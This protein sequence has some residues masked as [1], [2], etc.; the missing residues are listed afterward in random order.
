MTN[1]VTMQICLISLFDPTPVDKAA[2]GRFIGIAEAAVKR[3]HSVQHFTSTFRHTSKKHRFPESKTLSF[4]EN[5]QVHFVHSAGYQKNM[6][7][8]RFWA[9]ADFAGK[10]IPKL[11]ASPRPDVIFV[12]MPP[13]SVADRVTNWAA[14]RGIPVILDVIDP[15]PD[16]FIKD[17]PMQLKGAARWAILPFARKLKRALRNC[18]GLS[19]I[20]REYIKWALSYADNKDLRTAYFYP[21]VDFAGI[22]EELDQLRR[23]NVPTGDKLRLIYAGSLASSYD[24]GCILEAARRLH[25]QYP[26]RTEFVI[27]GTGPQEAEIE[28]FRDLP[29]LAYL[30][31]LQR[32]E[33]I[34]QYYLSDLGF[35]QH[36]NSL[37]QTVTYKLFSYLSA[38][39]PV[40]NSLQSEMVEIIEEHEVG[41]NNKEG[42]VAQLVRNIEVFLRDSAKL[43]QYKKNALRLT[44]EQGDVVV[45]YDRLV[46]YLEEIADLRVPAA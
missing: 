22:R 37:T 28:K 29:N 7:P 18:A 40:L 24:I 16:S 35:I 1:P 31:W 10:L 12:S 17:V 14:A 27:A 2:V 39:L 8:R 34:R 30:G 38:G 23:S 42:D 41:L 11:E 5:Y 46:S 32:E 13:L 15:W 26:G 6:S 44:A 25:Q 20:S 45:V 9:H 36:K 19:A 4:G 43:E 3:G 21:A 33:L